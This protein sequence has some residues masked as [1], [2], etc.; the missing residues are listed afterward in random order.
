[1]PDRCMTKTGKTSPEGVYTVPWGIYGDTNGKKDNYDKAANNCK[2][3]I[4]DATKIYVVD[5]HSASPTTLMN[6]A[7]EKLKNIDKFQ[8]ADMYQLIRS[9]TRFSADTAM[10]ILSGKDAPTYWKPLKD[11]E[12]NA[13]DGAAYYHQ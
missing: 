10:E 7:S 2:G 8:G 6:N 5:V 9:I 13:T 1:M 12:F 11:P 4:N 3:I